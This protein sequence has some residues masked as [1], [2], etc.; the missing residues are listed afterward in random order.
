M[1]KILYVSG[2]LL[3]IFT[4]TN[5][6]YVNYNS[7]IAILLCISCFLILCGLFYEKLIKIKWLA[8]SILALCSCYLIFV[9]FLGLYGKSDNVTYNEDAVI[10]L[11]AGIR[12]E[13]VLPLLANRL[14]KAAEYY[15]NNQNAVIVV[16]GGQGPGEDITE[17]LAME[18]YLIEKGVPKEQIFKE[19]SSTS[20]YENI[21]FSKEILDILFD[22]S[23][24]T[25]IITSDF[26]IFRA[27]QVAEKSG[28]NAAHYHA[29]IYWYNIP[30]YYVRETA[31]VARL[32]LLG[33]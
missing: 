8:Y 10:V 16:S 32:W 28:L 31:A 21:S 5:L 26:H 19:E 24:E 15:A 33:I 30:L 13:T 23:Y 12:G 25:V 6:F 17:A 3:F 18:R 7:G 4:L 14:D 29:K 1:K 11:G 22:D 27:V 9:L 2:F 20:T